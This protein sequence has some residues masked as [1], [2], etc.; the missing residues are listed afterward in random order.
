[1]NAATNK[2]S[3]FKLL[4][5]NLAIRQLI[6]TYL[7]TAP[8]A[9]TE[10]SYNA[11]AMKHH[12]ALF[13]RLKNMD[14]RQLQQLAE[15]IQP[16][17]SISV[18]LQQMSSICNDFLRKEQKFQQQYEHAKWL[19]SNDASNRQILML[20][21]LLETDDIRRLR[22]ETNT[23]VS[24]GRRKMPN[25]D[26]RLAVQALWQQSA[27]FN[28][29]IERL[30]VLKAAFPELGLGQLHSIINQEGEIA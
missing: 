12:H 2:L 10:A 23:P 5:P 19:I 18:N 22:I 28:C 7:A 8:H 21:D 24:K 16:A 25:I 9:S 15:H 14:A 3:D 20:C 13:G 30:R 11:L 27:S 26:V 4:Q 29:P 17:V 1:M 6:M